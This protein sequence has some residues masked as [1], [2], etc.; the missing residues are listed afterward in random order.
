MDLVSESS[1]NFMIHN[2]TKNSWKLSHVCVGQIR[3]NHFLLGKVGNYVI[4]H[5]TSGHDL[6]SCFAC[7]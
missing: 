3:E 7:V 6:T 5:G 2:I 4:S 1:I